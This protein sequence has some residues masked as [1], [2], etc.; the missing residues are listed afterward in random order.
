MCKSRKKW[1]SFFRTISQTFLIMDE[2][3]ALLEA[4]E[5]PPPHKKPKQNPYAT[6]T[7]SNNINN[8]NSG[9]EFASVFGSCSQLAK[10][11]PPPP[12]LD[13]ASK[14]G[15]V[16][17]QPQPLPQPPPQPNQKPKSDP[18]LC[19]YSRVRISNRIISTQQLDSQTLIFGSSKIKSIPNL[20]NASTSTLESLSNDFATFG[21]FSNYQPSKLSKSGGKAYSMWNLYDLPSHTHVRLFLFGDAFSAYAQKKEEGHLFL[22][23]GPSVMENNG[24]SGG[25]AGSNIVTLR[26]NDS[27]KIV[28]VGKAKDYASC[29]GVVRGSGGNPNES[30]GCK[31]I[32]DSRICGYCEYHKRQDPKFANKVATPGRNFL[33]KTNNFGINNSNNSNISNNSSGSGIGIGSG[34]G[35]LYSYNPNQPT[36]NIAPFP[37]P[38]PQPQPKSKLS[39]ADSIMFK[40]AMNK[41][42]FSTS[43]SKSKSKSKYDVAVTGASVNLGFNSKNIKTIPIPISG[44]GGLQVKYADDRCRVLTSYKATKANFGSWEKEGL[45]VVQVRTKETKL[46]GRRMGMGM[47]MGLGTVF[48]AL[49]FGSMNPLLARAAEEAVEYAELPK[50]YIPIVFA[51]VLLVGI[52]VLTGSLG[53]VIADEALLGDRSG[54]RAKKESERS[55]RS[56]FKDSKGG[57]EGN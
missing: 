34:S 22:L 33:Q 44:V 26:V 57:R 1:R 3:L 46:D 21:I 37:P 10:Q 9:N 29:R 28:K 45:T 24:G 32:V 42:Q 55:R 6:T 17:P 15:G 48:G 27:R 39:N 50:P 43:K 52:G 8:Q 5:N 11:Q 31:K 40:A 19:R 38:Q 25:T 30:R 54:A 51:L 2:V 14:F 47:G 41:T 4:E 13:F 56:F 20:I 18:L 12:P 35:N 49:A 53:D 16:S 36:K 7:R 23:L